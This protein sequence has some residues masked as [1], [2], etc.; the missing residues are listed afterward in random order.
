MSGRRNDPA[1]PLTENGRGRRDVLAEA[2][3]AHI[4]NDPLRIALLRIA[5]ETI[6]WT[7]RRIAI[8]AL[9]EAAGDELGDAIARALVEELAP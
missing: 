4:V 1:A 5:S 9:A 8:D 6:D 2:F 7:A 3:A